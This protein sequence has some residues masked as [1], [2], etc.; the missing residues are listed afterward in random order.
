MIE[1]PKL[2]FTGR[3]AVCRCGAERPSDRELPY[4]V[5]N[6]P[7]SMSAED[8]CICGFFKTAHMSPLPAYLKPS[9]TRCK[10]KFQARGNRQDHFW[11]GCGNQD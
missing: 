3:V 4:F 7:G 6:G 9:M 10:G 2:D 5:Y 1:T 8:T 11:C